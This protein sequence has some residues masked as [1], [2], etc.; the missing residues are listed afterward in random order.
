MATRHGLQCSAHLCTVF[1]PKS[2]ASDLVDICMP[3]LTGIMGW[4]SK[5]EGRESRSLDSLNRLHVQGLREPSSLF[6]IARV[7]F[8]KVVQMCTQSEQEAPQD[9]GIW[10]SFVQITSF[11]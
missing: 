9:V 4:T 6:L 7:L 2:P 10:F 5:F 11:A 3:D 8:A 1:D